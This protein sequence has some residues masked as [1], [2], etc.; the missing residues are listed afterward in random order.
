[1]EKG[2]DDIISSLLN[3]APVKFFNSFKEYQNLVRQAPPDFIYGGLAPESAISGVDFEKMLQKIPTQYKRTIFQLFYTEDLRDNINFIQNAL[4]D[5]KLLTIQSYTS[6]ESLKFMTPRSKE[7]IFH[8]VGKEHDLP[9]IF[10]ESI[11]QRMFTALD[12]VVKL[13]AAIDFEPPN[14]DSYCKNKNMKLQW[15]DRTRLNHYDFSI[16]EKY[17]Y[18]N[19][20]QSLRND[21]THDGS[22]EACRRIYYQ[23]DKLGITIKK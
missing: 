23:T 7:G 1:M 4:H 12:L 8:S 2:L 11:F 19:E 16:L 21:F 20:L 9:F 15:S 13:C 14:Y 17:K 6:L 22:W 18:F 3:Y 10:L 5:I